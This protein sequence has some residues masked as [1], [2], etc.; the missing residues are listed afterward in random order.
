MKIEYAYLSPIE[1]LYWDAAE[2]KTGKVDMK[3]FI[4]AV[5]RD[6]A[7]DGVG[8]IRKNMVVNSTRGLFAYSL[9]T[10]T[11]YELETF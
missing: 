6:F 1:K 9:G 5:R 2:P 3:K 4:K 10:D 7:D 8:E 11:W